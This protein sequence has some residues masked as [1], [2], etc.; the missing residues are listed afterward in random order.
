MR[1]NGLADCVLVESVETT[2]ISESDIGNMFSCL[3]D[4]VTGDQVDR[5]VVQRG[6]GPWFITALLAHRQALALEPLPTATSAQKKRRSSEVLQRPDH[7]AGEEV[8]DS[9]IPLPT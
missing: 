6:L 5:G 2:H 4:C 8:R 3:P 1:E 9:E 7:R